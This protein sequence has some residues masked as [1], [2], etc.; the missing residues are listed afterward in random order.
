ADI[1]GLTSRA[2][3]GLEV[4][5]SD[6]DPRITEALGR[7]DLQ[8][9]MDVLA[10]H[11]AIVIADTGTGILEPATQ[12]VL[13]TA[14]Q[15]VVCAAPSIDAS[16][17]TALTLDWLDQN[18]Y[19][20]LVE[21]AVVTINGVQDG[22][23]DVDLLQHYFEHRVRAVVRV[24]FDRQLAIGGETRL[25]ELAPATRSAYLTLA[26]MV[27]AGFGAPIRAGAGWRG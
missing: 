15:I 1:R 26:A 6:N 11:Y 5:A 14:D 21:N 23:G 7:P 22:I 4:V 3:S 13:A 9:V 24:P 10:R 8:Q 12:G 2:P 18:G 19:R 25:E 20:E 27:A 17:V 16:R